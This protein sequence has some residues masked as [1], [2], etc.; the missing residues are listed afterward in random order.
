MRY[1][2]IGVFCENKAACYKK[3]TA[4]AVEHLVVLIAMFYVP[5]NLTH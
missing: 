2:F 4:C 3:Q 5:V 1:T